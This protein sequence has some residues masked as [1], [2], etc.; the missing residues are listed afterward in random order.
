M[1]NRFSNLK[2]DIQMKKLSYLMLFFLSVIVYG[3]AEMEQPYVG[4]IVVDDAELPASGGTVTLT[5]NTDISSPIIVSV[6]DG[7]SWCTV[8]SSGK[9]ITVTATEANPLRDGRTATISVRCGYRNETFTVTQQY[10]GQ[11]DEIDRSNWTADGNS[12][13]VGDGGGYPS[14]FDDNRTTFWH[15]NYS[16]P[17]PLPYVIVVDM[18]EEHT[19]YMFRV[20]RRV[21]GTSNYPSVKH[22]NIYTST[23]N[24]DFTK[25]GEFTFEL[26]WIAP[27]GTEVTGNSSKIPGYEE[28][29]LDQSVVARYIK[30]EI[31]ETNGSVAQVSYIKAYEKK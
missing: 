18:Q 16:N 29:I 8:T 4:Y 27:D 24:V 23:D 5:A 20:G 6:P 10:E 14:L 25:V 26:P 31:T 9:D 15:S 11:Q 30:M 19:C 2:I 22:M 1:I 3:C 17:V 12:V 21:Y 13:E 28:I 7:I